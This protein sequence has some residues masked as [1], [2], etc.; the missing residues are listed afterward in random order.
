MEPIKSWIE[1]KILGDEKEK[2]SEKIKKY[3]F[4]KM[5]KVYLKCLL[6]ENIL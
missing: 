4:K 3:K 1:E 2:H 5:E 6:Y